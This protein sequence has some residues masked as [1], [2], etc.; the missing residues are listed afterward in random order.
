MSCLRRRSLRA[1]N[2]KIG[3]AAALNP[4]I[5][6]ADSVSAGFA[7]QFANADL[8]IAQ[9]RAD[10]PPISPPNAIALTAALKASHREPCARI[11][12]GAFGPPRYS[13]ISASTMARISSQ[14][15]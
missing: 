5:V 6:I 15:C 10:L 3:F 4:S 13:A 14:Y 9:P 1:A 8:S 7:T 12:V 11:A 2:R